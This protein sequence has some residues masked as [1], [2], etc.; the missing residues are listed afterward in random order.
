MAPSARISHRGRSNSSNLGKLTRSTGTRPQ[1]LTIW[2]PE[3]RPIAVWLN[4]RSVGIKDLRYGAL[5]EADWF[6]ALGAFAWLPW[7][8]WGL[9]RALGEADQSD[10]LRSGR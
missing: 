8:W 5:L 4:Q 6:G 3:T 7:A 1:V 9:E 10:G 2:L